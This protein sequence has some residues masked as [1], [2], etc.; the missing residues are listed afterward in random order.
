MA[1]RGKK[2]ASVAPASVLPLPLQNDPSFVASPP[3]DPP[4]KKIRVDPIFVDII[5]TLQG[6]E[7][8]NAHC[9]DMMVAFVVPS[10]STPKSERHDVQQL[11][12]RMIGDTLKDHQNKLIEVVAAAKTELAELEGSKSSLL[13]CC[14]EAKRLL[15]ERQ[16]AKT[17]AEAAHA[18]A[19]AGAETSEC[20]LS[21]AQV[22]KKKGDDAMVAIE[23]ARADINA[24]YLEHFKAPMDMNEGPHHAFLKPFIENLGLEESLINALPSSCLKTQ[25][26]RGGFD[27]LVL[28]QL[29]KALLAKIAALEKS[30]VDE[31]TADSERKGAVLAAQESLE[32]KRIAERTA[33]GNLEAAMTAQGESEEEVSKATKHWEELEPRVK[34]T[35]DRLHSHETKQHE[36]EE[37]ALKNFQTLQ[38][39]EASMPVEEAASA[40]A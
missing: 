20:A 8:I 11:G 31:A 14:E 24:V 26:Q 29:E 16:E 22:L 1:P 12:V 33:A 23:K 10:L 40:G 4:A 36:F 30:L 5:A 38:D 39:K 6:A 13:Q 17:A 9:R 7:D 2:R 19:K 25:E 35:S 34:E 37:G 21:E 15:G 3:K 27:N 18:E 28:E 32:G